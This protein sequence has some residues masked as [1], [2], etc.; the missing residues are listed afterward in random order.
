MS[1]GKKICARCGK[2][3][4]VHQEDYEI[5]EKMHWLCFHLEY[6]HK[7]D[8]D[9]ACND[10]SCPWWQ[11]H[12]F[13]QKLKELEQDPDEVLTVEYAKKELQ[14]YMSELSE[15]AYCAGWNYGLEYAL[16][17]AVIE[18]PKTYGRLE[19]TEEHISKLKKLSDICQ[20]WIYFDK[21]EGETFIPLDRWLVLYQKNKDKH[22]LY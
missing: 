5:F 6:E 10:P 19:I 3:V 16:W 18:G 11:I 4:V 22:V 20:G 9:E 15:A 14:Y 21:Q 17:T 1:S 2:A 12:I 8:P 13:R 7:A